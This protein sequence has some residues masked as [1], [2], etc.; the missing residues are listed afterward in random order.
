M[1]KTSFISLSLFV[2][3]SLILPSCSDDYED[4]L[5]TCHRGGNIDG[6]DDGDSSDVSNP[7]DTVP[8]GPSVILKDWKD[9]IQTDLKL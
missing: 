2:I 7:S 4:V 3:C 5:C 1:R 9:S 8:P 6:W